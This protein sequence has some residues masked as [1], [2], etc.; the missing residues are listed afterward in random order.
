MNVITQKEMKPLINY[1][2]KSPDQTD[3]KAK[4]LLEKMETEEPDESLNGTLIGTKRKRQVVNY[5]E[6]DERMEVLMK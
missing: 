4:D 6:S 5:A 3:D 2:I 1:L